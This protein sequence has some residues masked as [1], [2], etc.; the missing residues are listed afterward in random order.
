MIDLEFDE[1]QQQLQ[2]TARS[3][4][5]AQ[6]PIASVRSLEESDA[7]YAPDLWKQMA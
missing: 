1:Q 2:R 3:F 4:F 6:C 5:A 7:G